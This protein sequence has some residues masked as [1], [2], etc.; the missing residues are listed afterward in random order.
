VT[1]KFKRHRRGWL[2]SSEGFEVRIMGR[3]DLEYRDEVC[4]LH[5]FVEPM[6]KYNDIA[7]YRSS[8][9]EHPHLSRAE[10]VERVRRI[11][12]ARGWNMLY[13]AEEQE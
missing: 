13:E 8:I 7:L 6:A 12:T 2:R 1:E 3:N 11:F 4:H 10:L 5:M 9:P